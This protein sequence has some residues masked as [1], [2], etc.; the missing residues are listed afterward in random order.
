MRSI[1]KVFRTKKP[2]ELLTS[3][4]FRFL[5]STS[6]HSQDKVCWPHCLALGRDQSFGKT[7]GLTKAFTCD[8]KVIPRKAGE[9]SGMRAGRAASE[10]PS[11]PQL[12][13][14]GRSRLKI[15]FIIIFHRCFLYFKFVTFSFLLEL[16]EDEKF[17]FVQYIFLFFLYR[18]SFRPIWSWFLSDIKIH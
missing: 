17:Y 4:P 7:R 6:T 8:S 3:L 12:L 18:I 2:S 1:L 16:T 14:A 5:I 15:F 10:W 9:I 11:L 13:V